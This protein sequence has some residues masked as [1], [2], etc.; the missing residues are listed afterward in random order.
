MIRQMQQLDPDQF[1][2]HPELVEQI[3]SRLV[4]A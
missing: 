2:N 1:P 4:A 3:I